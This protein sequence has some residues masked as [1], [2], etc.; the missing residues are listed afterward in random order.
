MDK[1]AKRRFRI[2]ALGV[3]GLLLF[4]AGVSFAMFSTSFKGSKTQNVNTGCLRVEMSDSGNLT[5]NNDYPVTDEEGLTRKPYT[6]T[7]KNTCTV[8]A[9]YETTLN[10]MNDS[11][12][13]NVDKVKVALGGDSYVAP[14]KESA[15]E[16]ATLLDEDVTGV[17][18]TYKLDEGYLAIGQTKTFELR[19]WIDYN[20]ESITGKLENKVIINS[21]SD[22]TGAIVYNTNTSGYYTARK[23]SVI[24]N[25]NYSEP[26]QESGLVKNKIKDGTVYNYRGNP[27]NYVLFGKYNSAV[28]NNASGSQIKWRVLSTNTDGSINLITDDIIANSKYSDVENAL[29]SFYN[30]HLSDEESYIKTDSTFCKEGATNNEYLAKLRVENHNP[31]A[32]C[33]G[34]SVTKIGLPTSN[35]LMYAGALYNSATTTYLSN[36]ASFLTNSLASERSVY[37][38]T[39]NGISEVDINAETGIK[40]VI[41]LKSNTMLGGTGTASDPFYVTGVYDSNTNQNN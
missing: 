19:T 3:A 35:D 17:Q 21:I 32:E 16:V 29:A 2:I 13:D 27:N 24:K 36:S 18:K 31:S 9:Y 30:K 25:Q 28:G 7:I 5:L 6:Y 20:V 40:A 4:T 1:E 22:N 26:T 37:A 12:L 8:D 23:N 14:I 10:V 15:L 34:I 33:S 39:A 38:H 41:T 11:N